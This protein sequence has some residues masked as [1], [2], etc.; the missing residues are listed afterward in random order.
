MY[1][2]MQFADFV[3]SAALQSLSRS[4]LKVGEHHGALTLSEAKNLAH[5][6]EQVLSLWQMAQWSIGK[7][8]FEQARTDLQ[9]MVALCSED[10]QPEL[11]AAESLLE[12][13]DTRAARWLEDIIAAL[14]A[15]RPREDHRERLDALLQA[16]SGRWRSFVPLRAIS[17]A[18]LIEHGMLRAF[19]KGA[20][21]SAK[22]DRSA[23][24][25]GDRRASARRLARTRRWIGHSVNHLEL[26][27][28]GLSES[29]RTRR[30]HLNR[31][32]AKLEDQWGLERLARTALVMDLKPKASVR[33]QGL[34]GDERRRLDKQRQKLSLGA[35]AGGGGAY[36]EEIG[37]AVARLG[38]DTITLLPLDGTGG[39]ASGGIAG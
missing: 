7:V 4:L 17:E 32:V 18:D 27:R 14:Q 24:A 19:E 22:L 13:A 16:E 20:A 30:W 35:F 34:I 1:G 36:R 37:D 38:L 39:G 3:V 9:E 21:L 26:L 12:R 11:A 28:P 33:L 25:D 6:A 8:Q 10:R 5:T 15:V 31:L 2:R 23:A 29:G